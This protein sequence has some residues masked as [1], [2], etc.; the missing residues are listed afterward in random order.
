MSS[1]RSRLGREQ[2]T[3][4]SIDHSSARTSR[5][6]GISRPS[7]LA[8]RKLIT[9]SNV[10]GCTVT[11]PFAPLDNDHSLE[12]IFAGMEWKRLRVQQDQQPPEWDGMN[13]SC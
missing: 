3:A 8:V 9:S 2:P 4:C 6:V 10:V 7:V 5:I 12:A 13:L 11:N 1:V